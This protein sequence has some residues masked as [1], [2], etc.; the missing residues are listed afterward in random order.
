MSDGKTRQAEENGSHIET[1]GKI[2]NQETGFMKQGTGNGFEL[3]YTPHP[4]P[5]ALYPDTR[6][7]F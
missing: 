3:P 2:R 1:A 4:T 7:F 5:L 6:S